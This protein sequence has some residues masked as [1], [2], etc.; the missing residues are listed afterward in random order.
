VSSPQ[1]PFSA[2][3]LKPAALRKAYFDNGFVQTPIYDRST[4]SPGHE[5]LGPAIIEQPDTT[6]VV[7]PGQR[8]RLYEDRSILVN[9]SHA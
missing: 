7:Y 9:I 2:E 5:I 4:M 6:L 8:A 1:Q 3:V